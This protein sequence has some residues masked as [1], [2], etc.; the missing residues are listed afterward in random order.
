MHTLSSLNTTPK[1]KW[2]KAVIPSGEKYHF[3]KNKRTSLKLAN[4]P[5]CVKKRVVRISENVGL[6][7]QQ[8]LWLWE[9]A[10]QEAV[11]FVRL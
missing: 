9:I 2:L 7:E 8:L 10:A 1:P 4:V 11:A 6:L 3:I 5:Q